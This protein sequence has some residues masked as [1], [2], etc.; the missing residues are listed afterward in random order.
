MNLKE[1]VNPPKQYRPSP[2]WSWNDVIEASEVET[3]IREMKRKGFGGFFIH[4]RTGLRT[5]Y[6]GEQWMQAVRRWK[7]NNF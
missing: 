6:L 5:E 2:F 3:G 4:S 7:E 1:F